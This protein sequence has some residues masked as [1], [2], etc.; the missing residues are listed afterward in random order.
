MRTTGKGSR[1]LGRAARDAAV[2]GIV[3]GAV[4]GGGAEAGGGVLAGGRER[5]SP[6]AALV[7]TTG[8]LT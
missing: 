8:S 5:T 4:D 2:V 6:V 7:A 3:A 1:R